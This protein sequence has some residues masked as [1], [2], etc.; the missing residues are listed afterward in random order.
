MTASKWQEWRTWRTYVRPGD[1]LVFLLAVGF[2]GFSAYSLWGADTPSTA[3]VRLRGQT[4][5]KLPL[6]RAITYNVQGP[7]GT[8]HIEIQPGRARVASDPG[9]RQYCVK[10]GWLSRSGAAAICAPNEV[11]LQ[12]EG[13]RSSYDTLTY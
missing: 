6:D 2:T 9:P 4:V 8:T 11:T 5:A 1:Y 13:R 12:L 3:V 7:L 10:Q